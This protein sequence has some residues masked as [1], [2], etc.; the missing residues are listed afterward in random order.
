MGGDG[1]SYHCARLRFA[2]IGL[3]WGKDRIGIGLLKALRARR[4]I[5]FNDNPSPAELIPPKSGHLVVCE[6]GDDIAQVIA[7]NYAFATG[8]GLHLIPETELWSEPR[9]TSKSFASYD[10][11][12]R[13]VSDTLTRLRQEVRELTGPVS[14]PAGGSI[15]FITDELPLGFA[16]PQVPCTHLFIYPNL[17]ISIVQGFL[18]AEQRDSPESGWNWRGAISGDMKVSF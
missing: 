2:S 1:P 12:H 13:S 10:N 7:A 6:E 5:V 14:I 9:G 3:E 4:S 18:L 8:A 11:P 15:T 16:F 17:G